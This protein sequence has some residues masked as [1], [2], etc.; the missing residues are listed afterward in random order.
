MFFAFEDIGTGRKKKKGKEH[1]KKQ[2]RGNLNKFSQGKRKRLYQIM[3]HHAGIR[4]KEKNKARKR[5]KTKDT[6]DK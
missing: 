4:R 2:K 3:R 1:K 6:D 5:E